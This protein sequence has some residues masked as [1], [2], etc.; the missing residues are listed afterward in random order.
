M[1]RES[2]LKILQSLLIDAEMYGG[3]PIDEKLLQGIVILLRDAIER[4]ERGE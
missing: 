4:R 3:L 2:E 1:D